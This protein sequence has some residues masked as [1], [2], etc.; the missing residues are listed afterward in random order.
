M[1]SDLVFSALHQLWK[2]A[3]Y[4][5]WQ[6]TNEWTRRLRLCFFM[7]C[8]QLVTRFSSRKIRLSEDLGYSCWDSA[9]GFN[10]HA[11]EPDVYSTI[12]VISIMSIVF[13]VFALMKHA[14]HLVHQQ[15][16]WHCSSQYAKSMMFL[17]ACENILYMCTRSL[18]IVA[19]FKQ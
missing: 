18:H 2:T 9:V 17:P 19:H 6:M 8:R 16:L 3:T 1:M 11:E 13:C 15:E 5:M 14:Q 4:V 7:P 10:G 12:W